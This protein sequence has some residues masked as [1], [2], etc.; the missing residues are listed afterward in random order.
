[1]ILP[2]LNARQFGSEENKMSRA[3]SEII[4]M[5]LRLHLKNAPE[6]ILEVDQEAAG[7][8]FCDRNSAV[9]VPEPDGVLK[10]YGQSGICESVNFVLWKE[11]ENDTGKKIGAKR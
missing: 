1:M 5:S 2:E 9:Q 4:S 10:S 6:Q 8:G 11:G 7:S 3:L